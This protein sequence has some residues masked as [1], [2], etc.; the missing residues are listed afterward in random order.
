MVFPSMEME[1]DPGGL[2]RSRPRG[3]SRLVRS[4]LRWGILAIAAGAIALLT[5]TLTL[6]QGAGGG[7]APLAIAT[8][9]P[10]Q[11]TLLGLLAVVL[12]IAINAFFV[13]AE[14]ALVSV[15]RS[16]VNQLV[17][18]GDLAA[19][20]VQ[21]LQRNI[22]RL[23]STTQLGITLSSLAL[24]WIGERAIALPLATWLSAHATPWIQ[25]EMTRGVSIGLAFL[26]V[27]YLQ[28]V[29]GELCPKSVALLHAEHL[30]RLLGPPSLAI[31]QIFHPFAWILNRST[32]FLLG[33]LGVRYT[34]QNWYSR[35]TPEELQLII[36][37]ATE[38]TGLEAEEREL[39]NNVFEFGEVTAGEVMVPR[40]SIAA[41]PKTARFADVLAEVA[42][43]G[44]SIYPVTGESLDDI[45]GMVR[46]MEL[47]EALAEGQL[48]DQSDI[49]PWIRPAKFVQEY[50]PLDE[51]L[52]MMQRMHR[53]MVMVVD[54]FGGTAGLVTLENVV[55]ELIG[56]LPS[57]EEEEVL[58]ETLDDRTFRVQ[59]QVDLEAVNGLLGVDL[60]LGDDYQTLGGFLIYQLQKIPAVGECL[61]YR[62]WA[63][64]VVS[65]DGPRLDRVRIERIDRGD[66]SGDDMDSLRAIA[67]MAEE[68]EDDRL[69]PL[70][71]D[72]QLEAI[73]ALTEGEAQDQSAE[74]TE[75]TPPPQ[76]TDP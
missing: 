12:L 54:E 38:S 30:A 37:T 48:T 67:A 70:D 43:S 75:L 34:G 59:A 74:P 46:V 6:A 28:I 42:E 18:E 40:T 26:L 35:V 22:E 63:F 52:R 76:R 25:P 14:F 60:P 10:A 24:G 44:H 50:T 49:A 56:D 58:L 32:R 21:Q 3:R 33:L 23:L 64:T 61:T 65:T 31:S 7:A 41:V 71:T 2:G 9:E 73:D 57:G 4:R 68:V 36:S 11:G 47:I 45:C 72:L 19:R 69:S 62:D 39:L 51:L 66:G 27:A 29:L 55:E 20:S 8:G 13:T 17:D 16:R 1:P 53:S 15:R 5:P